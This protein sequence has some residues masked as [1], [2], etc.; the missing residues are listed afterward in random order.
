MVRVHRAVTQVYANIENQD[1]SAWSEFIGFAIWAAQY[2]PSL[3]SCPHND[4]D[5]SNN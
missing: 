4:E 2:H 5:R 1:L 3:V